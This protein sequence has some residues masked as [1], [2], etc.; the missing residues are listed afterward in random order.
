LALALAAAKQPGADV[1]SLAGGVEM[2]LSQLKAA[3][4]SHGMTEINPVGAAFDANQHE[5]IAAQP[6]AEV[7]EGKV[8]NV[9]RAGFSLNGRLLR[10]AS[11]LVSSGPAK[12]AQENRK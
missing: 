1:K 12:S 4:G 10:P 6:S 8:I 2:V 9:V 7:P 5:S 3:L 11:V